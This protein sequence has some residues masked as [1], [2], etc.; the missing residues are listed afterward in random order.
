MPHAEGRAEPRTHHEPAMGDPLDDDARAKLF[1]TN[2]RL[3]LNP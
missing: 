3:L 1:G 2:A